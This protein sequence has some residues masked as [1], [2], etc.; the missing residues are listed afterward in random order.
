MGG[1]FAFLFVV[2]DTLTWKDG[3]YHCSH[4]ATKNMN[5]AS[6]HPASGLGQLMNA[7]N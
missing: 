6:F 3:A 4:G 7:L 5:L 2:L 1:N